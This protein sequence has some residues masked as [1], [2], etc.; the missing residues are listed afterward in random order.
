MDYSET[1]SLI[2]RT[3]PRSALIFGTVAAF[4]SERHMV[5]AVLEPSGVETGWC[6]CLQGA[7]ADKIG[8]EVLMGRAGETGACQYIVLGIIE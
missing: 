5:K 2:K 6:K 3:A 4:D 1:V 8:L 7:Y